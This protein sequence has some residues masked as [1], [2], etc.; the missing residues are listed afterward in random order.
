MYPLIPESIGK[1]TAEPKC[2]SLDRDTPRKTLSY[3][4]SYPSIITEARIPIVA[5]CDPERLHETINL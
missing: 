2:F 1:N 4:F 5:A 3:I